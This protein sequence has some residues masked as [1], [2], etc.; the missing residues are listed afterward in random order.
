[1]DTRALSGEFLP[2]GE[3]L[4]VEM[5]TEAQY[6]ARSRLTARMQE[7]ECI[8]DSERKEARED[9]SVSFPD[10]DHMW[11]VYVRGGGLRD[12]CHIFP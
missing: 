9:S 10:I 12:S 4:T 3:I 5:K 7:R 2:R 8:P 11:S 6:R 1:M